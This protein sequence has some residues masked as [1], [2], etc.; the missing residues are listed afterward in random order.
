MR[1]LKKFLALVLAT[2]ML[3]GATVITTGAATEGDYSDAAQRLAA[4]NILK[5]DQSGNL[6]LDQGVTRWHT[7]LFFVQALTGRTDGAEWNAVKNSDIFTDVPEYGTAIDYAAGIGLIKGRGN[8]I[9]G[10]SDSIIYQDMLVMA[11]RALG[12]ETEDMQ[13]PYGHIMAAEKLGLNENMSKDVDYK[14]ALTRGETAQIIWN[15]LG[16]EMAFVD[17]LTKKVLYPGDPSIIGAI[18]DEPKEIERKTMLEEAGF[19]HDVIEGVIVEYEE[20]KLSSDVD[21]VTLD[22]GMVL[23]AEH[24]GITEKTRKDSYLNLPVTLYINCSMADFVKE[25]DEEEINPDAQVIFTE[26]LSFTS[27]VN[28]GNEANIKFTPATETK[29]E[30]ITLGGARFPADKYFYDLRVLDADGRG[31]DGWVEGD[32]ALLEN[33]LYDTKDGQI[34]ENSYGE[35]RYTV[36]TDE[37]T[38]DQTLLMLY[39]PFAFGRYHTRSLRYTPTVKDTSFVLVATYDEDRAGLSSY[40][41]KSDNSTLF[42]ERTLCDNF[43]TEGKIVDINTTSLSERDGEASATVT[44]T[45]EAVKNNQ[46]MF[47]YYNA[48]DNVL[49]VGKACGASKQ[50]VLSSYSTKN[51]TVKVDGK[52]YDFGFPGGFTDTELPAFDAG[53]VQNYL[54]QITSGQKNVNYIAVDDNI[55]YLGGVDNSKD[56]KQHSFVVLSTDAE[57][58]A[59]LLDITETKY[60]NQVETDGGLYLDE[61]GNAAVAALNVSTGKWELAAVKDYEFGNYDANEDEF[62]EYVNVAEGLANYKLFGERY[63]QYRDLVGVIDAINTDG[64]FLVRANKSKV[65]T[66]APINAQSDACIEYGIADDGLYFSDAAAKTNPVRGVKD[67]EVDKARLTLSA[68]SVVVLIDAEGEIGVR[69]GIQKNANSVEA[70]GRFYSA[71]NTLI[72]LKL[73]GNYDV[74]AWESNNVNSADET[75]YVALKDVD[76]SYERLEDET[77]DITVTGLFNLR[78]FKTVSSIKVN[79]ESLDEAEWLDVLDPGVGLHMKANGKLELYNDADALLKATDMRDDDDEAFEVVDLADVAF[80]DADTFYAP[81]L[82]EDLDGIK[83]VAKIDI[84]VATIDIS[85]YDFDK[86]YSLDD[87]VLVEEYDE[88]KAEEWGGISSV[89]YN[90]D[91]DKVYAYN[92]SD[93]GEVT[94]ISA[95]TAGVFDQYVLDTTDGMLNIYAEGDDY[96]E[97]AAKASVIMTAVGQFDDETGV[98]TIYVLKALTNH[99]EA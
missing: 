63:T 17:P 30:A 41:N 60:L 39:M 32:T 51:E 48:L 36:I 66:I 33:F 46:F 26:L 16:T 38:G 98:L 67:T 50:G 94:E 43:V 83:A 87:I 18:G 74:A 81:D 12:Y 90:A 55:V 11:V 23:N 25:Y 49:N 54:S 2:L 14:D 28:I 44:V 92:L 76:A 3:V 40:K 31:Q 85:D 71:T 8:G 7:A 20:G 69:T 34:G 65:Y 99:P 10:Y 22:N 97:T 59:D 27:V 93:L 95:P 47:Y 1:N 72:V 4:I 89:K 96:F 68:K 29:A 77:Y 80:P 5:G 21:T 70:N 37:E 52:T 84:T 57:I 73:D 53:R 35:I 15:M 58:M 91:G 75:Y 13:Y 88:D 62:S 6:M 64:I 45:G 56:A 24:L 42:I 19:A 78:T 86:D 82:H 79:V 61:N 9:Y